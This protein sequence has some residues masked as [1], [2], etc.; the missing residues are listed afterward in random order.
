MYVDYVIGLQV[1]NYTK[2]AGQFRILKFVINNN[3]GVIIQCNVFENE[4]NRFELSIKANQV[5]YYRG[6]LVVAN[7]IK[8][9]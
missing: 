6:V 9:I 4:I 7:K 1:H 3:D 2:K 5:T 8:K